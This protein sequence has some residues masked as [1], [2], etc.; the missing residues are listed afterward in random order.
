MGGDR[1]GRRR[2]DKL[3]SMLKLASGSVGEKQGR[4]IWETSSDKSWCF[5]VMS[6]DLHEGSMLCWLHSSVVLEQVPSRDKLTCQWAPK[7]L[8]KVS[9]LENN[10][11][12]AQPEGIQVIESDQLVPRWWLQNESPCSENHSFGI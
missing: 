9:L 8:Y 1:S 12:G 2:R 11:K 7:W 6:D 10:K 4:D 5:N 3:M